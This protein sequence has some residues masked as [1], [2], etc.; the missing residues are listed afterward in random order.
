MIN[1]FL[2]KMDLKIR[3]DF[4]FWDL[5]FLKVYAFIP[6]LVLGAYFPDSI[7]NYL[8]FLLIIFL[9]LASRY[10]YLLFMK[11]PTHK[12]ESTKQ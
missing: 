6:G 10:F 9:A 11:E 8:W 2:R 7:K 12:G 4:T 5:A 3:N 1:T